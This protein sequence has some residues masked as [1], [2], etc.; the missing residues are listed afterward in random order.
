MKVYLT[1]PTFSMLS[2]S[3]L[4]SV[5]PLLS[6]FTLFSHSQCSCLFSVSLSWKPC[7]PPV[8]L[9]ESSQSFP[10]FLVTK[11]SRSYLAFSETQSFTPVCRSPSHIFFFF[12]F[13]LVP[14]QKLS[15]CPTLPS[16]TS[17]ALTWV[18]SVTKHSTQDDL[19]HIFL[20][21]QKY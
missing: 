13:V 5:P 17:A 19:R 6:L 2:P 15:L 21:I 4:M 18:V 10:S 8:T 12:P 14:Q 16:S 3:F 11:P 9:Q 1:G 20:L 7:S